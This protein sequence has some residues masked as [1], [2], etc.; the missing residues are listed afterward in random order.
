MGLISRVSSRTY[1]KKMEP[2]SPLVER[3]FLKTLSEKD[4]IIKF[5]GIDD[6]DC[7]LLLKL[8]TLTADC[9]DES[10]HVVQIVTLNHEDQQVTGTLCSLNLEHN[11]SVSLDGFSVAPPLALK[12]VQGKGPIS[13]CGN[14]MIE[15][16]MEEIESDESDE[17]P[18]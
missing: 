3:T 4:K 7:K 2:P 16:E 18:E 6:A 15:V 1:R 13:I 11:C 5:D 17:N 14:L 10:R 12:L 8:A 9:E